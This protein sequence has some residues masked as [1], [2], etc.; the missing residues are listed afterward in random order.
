[1]RRSWAGALITSCLMHI[2][3]V[4]TGAWLLSQ[5][6]G[7]AEHQVEIVELPRD[8]GQGIQLPSVRSLLEQPGPSRE[9]EPQGR[10][11]TAPEPRGGERPAR[12]D[13]PRAGRGG[14]PENS[15][16]ALNLSDRVVPLH[17]SREAST[18]SEQ[19]QIQRLRTA[20]QRQS[21]DDRRATPNP[22]EL[23]FVTT[24]PGRLLE[25]R[26]A[27][28]TSARGYA[29]VRA[30]SRDGTR[31]GN[32]P[33]GDGAGQRVGGVEGA[34]VQH[35][36]GVIEGDVAA[37]PSFSAR[38]IT[39][40][41]PVKRAR[42]AVPANIRDRPHDTTDSSHKVAGAIR[43]LVHAGGLGGPIGTAPGGERGPSAPG[44]DGAEGAGAQ[45]SPSGEGR[46]A[47]VSLAGDSGFSRYYRRL[48]D[49]VDW[50][51][52]F[53]DWAIAQGMG[54]LAV[55]GLTL[56]SDGSVRAVSIVRPSGIAEFDNN[57]MAAIRRHGPYGPL[58]TAAGGRLSVQIAF[59]ATNPAVGREGGGPGGRQR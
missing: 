58:P 15:V 6:F 24:G 11:E 40:R 25:R 21:L 9:T 4:G 18:Y 1:M 37:R 13:L 12:P 19:S 28:A 22:S 8:A 41:P 51:R 23:T 56:G 29:I 27:A 57:L 54:G 5:A 3:L 48:L 14:T 34:R 20:R 55:V 53:P 46:G 2:G 49:R 35:A 7:E 45:A 52:A 31:R 59:D 30:A 32:A 43:S 44:R 38:V 10:P 26:P 33:P 36:Q 16:A 17:L 39:A 50:S 47:G 42:A